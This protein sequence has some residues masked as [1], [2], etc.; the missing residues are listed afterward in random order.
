[1][2]YVELLLHSNNLKVTTDPRSGVVSERLRRL[3][4]IRFD[5]AARGGYSQPLSRSEPSRFF[6][7]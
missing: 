5:R 6:F 2:R 3:V 1:M 7:P 4:Q